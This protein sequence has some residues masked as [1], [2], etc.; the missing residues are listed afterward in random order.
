[1]SPEYG[2][3]IAESFKKYLKTGNHTL[4]EKYSAKE[5]KIA[6]SRLSPYYDNNKKWYRTLEDRIAEL[7]NRPQVKIKPLDRRKL[8][9]FDRILAFLFGTLFG[10]FLVT[11]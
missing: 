4:I 9:Q 1:M 11:L 6:V 7:E 5:L 2:M 3:N 10:V 8:V